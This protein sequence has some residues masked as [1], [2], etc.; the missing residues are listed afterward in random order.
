M[1]KLAAG[2]ARLG[3]EFGNC[4]LEKLPGKKESGLQRDAG[5][6]PLGTAPG[7]RL[8]LGAFAGLAGE[9]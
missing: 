5:D 7:R 8:D 9:A 2:S 4:R 3:Q 6:A 1:G